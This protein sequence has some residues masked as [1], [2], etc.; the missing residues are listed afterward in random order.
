MGVPLR[1]VRFSCP[2]GYVFIQSLNQCVF[3]VVT[4]GITGG[5][6]INGQPIAPPVIQ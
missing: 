3:P 4:P 2:N 5:L 1:R 6:N